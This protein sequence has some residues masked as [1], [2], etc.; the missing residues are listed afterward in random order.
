MSK[1]NADT[2][3]ITEVLPPSEN[4]ETISARAQT[5]VSVAVDAPPAEIVNVR[6]FYEAQRLDY[7]KR[8]ADIE[9]FLGF[10]EASDDLSVRVSRL[11][12]FLGIK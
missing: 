1:K 3:L 11:E 12:N 8:V 10:V 2:D 6:A 9:I 7:M 4:V 5:I